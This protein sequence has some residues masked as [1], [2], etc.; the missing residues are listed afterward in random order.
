[1]SILAIEVGPE[2]SRARVASMLDSTAGTGSWDAVDLHAEAGMVMGA[3]ARW[4]V[5]EDEKRPAVIDDRARGLVLGWDGRLDDRASLVGA[6]GVSSELSSAALAL[7]AFARWGDDAP[8]HLIGDFVFVVFDRASR[9]LFVARDRFGIR[10]MYWLELPQGGV[11][12]SSDERALF[13]HGD[14]TPR[15]NLRVLSRALAGAAVL[16]R[17]TLRE[18][19]RV[20][21]AGTSLAIVDGRAVEARYYTPDPGGVDESLSRADHLERIRAALEASIADRIRGRWPIASQASGGL[22]SS[23]VIAIASR[24]LARQDRPPP[25]LLHMRCAALAC[26]EHRFAKAVA[27]RVGAELVV[28]DGSD[29]VYEPSAPREI[30]LGGPWCAPYAALYGEAVRRGARVVLTGE[31][32]DE[33]QLRHGLEVDDALVR[34]SWL[35]AASFAGLFDEPLAKASWARLARAALRTRA[36]RALRDWR[37]S[38]R[39]PPALPPWLSEDAKRWA[40]EGLSELEE[41]QRSVPHP[42][43]LRRAACMELTSTVGMTLIMQEVQAFATHHGVELSHPFLDLRVVDAFM[44]LPTRLRT[45]PD[46]IK[47][48]LRAVMEGELP[49]EVLW[50]ARP[51]DYTE[52]HASAWSAPSGA[53]I[54]LARSSKLARLGLVNADAFGAAVEDA[55]ANALDGTALSS[56]V[57]NAL[58]LEGWLDRRLGH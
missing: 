41:M 11:R 18:G 30:D 31:G 39:R 44:A 50:K 19:V 10:P 42:S 6:L 28:E 7:E 29:A 54:C 48:S 24:Q 20:I 33:L 56:D 15:P 3:R 1:M 43:P 36:P 55:F 47:P 22:D 58:E 21:P 4:T 13:A 23:T 45:D 17:D 14:L 53:W 37:A 57:T 26:D 8:R 2:A 32:S 35:E 12:L 46:L 27:D 51:T 40:L 25:L 38:R 52:L 34:S 5:P 9:R 49:T 16:R